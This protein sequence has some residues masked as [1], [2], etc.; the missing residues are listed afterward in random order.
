MIIGRMSAAEVAFARDMDRQGKLWFY[1]PKTFELPEPERS[2][3][4]DFYVVEDN[5]FVE[6][7]GTRQAYS[8]NR[9]KYEV[10]RLAY[11]NLKF[12]IVDANGWM[13]SNGKPRVERPKKNPACLLRGDITGPLLKMKLNSPN[14]LCLKVINLVESGR[15]KCMKEIARHFGISYWPLLQGCKGNSRVSQKTVDFLLK[16]ISQ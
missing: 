16:A 1:H 4:P 13:Y 15:F 9:K 8:Y 3:Q 14:E 5:E 10:F 11:P 12:R 6:V 2:Y 7:A